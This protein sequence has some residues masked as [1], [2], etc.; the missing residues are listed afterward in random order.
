LSLSKML[1]SRP[2]VYLTEFFRRDQWPAR[3]VPFG[4]SQASIGMIGRDQD[5]RD[6]LAQRDRAGASA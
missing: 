4:M 2:I 1:S 3:T 6:V 5:D